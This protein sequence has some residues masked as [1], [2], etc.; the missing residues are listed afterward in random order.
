MEAHPALRRE[1]HEGDGM[2]ENGDAETNGKADYAWARE[3]AL[4]RVGS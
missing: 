3:A 4:A 1:P 2:S